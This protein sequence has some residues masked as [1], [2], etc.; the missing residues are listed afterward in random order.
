[1]DLPPVDWVGGFV[2]DPILG[3][4][5]MVGW[6][7]FESLGKIM[8]GDMAIDKQ[9]RRDEFLLIILQFFKRH[10][11]PSTGIVPMEEPL[12]GADGVIGS[13]GGLV[14]ENVEDWTGHPGDG[15]FRDSRTIGLRQTG[16]PTT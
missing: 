3:R 5:E 1:M 2:P 14:H 6:I 16:R 8:F 15:L 7:R 13:G 10:V 12:F 4:L 11:G 9:Y